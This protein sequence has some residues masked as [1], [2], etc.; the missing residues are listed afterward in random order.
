MSKPKTVKPTKSIS[1]ESGSLSQR[2]Y[3]VEEQLVRMRR[4]NEDIFNNIGSGN[5]DTEL[6]NRLSAIE[7]NIKS[8]QTRLVALEGNQEGV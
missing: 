4:D 2:L 7:R 5:L 1:S 6:A 8:I 3:E